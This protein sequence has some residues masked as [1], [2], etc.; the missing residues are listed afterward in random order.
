MSKYSRNLICS[1]RLFSY[2]CNENSNSNFELISDLKK[3]IFELEQK[4]KLNQNLES[5]YNNLKN[6]YDNQIL[7]Q[8]QKECALKTNIENLS[9]LN[10][11]IKTENENLKCE[12]EK[13]TN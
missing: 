10:N 6:D 9:K 2:D 5:K 11:E 1:P 3:K 7:F 4:E 8:N 12:I 13:K